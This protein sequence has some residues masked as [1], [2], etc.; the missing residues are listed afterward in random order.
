MIWRELKEA[1]ELEEQRLGVSL[2][3]LD[4]VIVDDYVE[5]PQRVVTNLH[6]TIHRNDA[7]GSRCYYPNIRLSV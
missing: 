2:D 3:D 1:V 6:A 5:G 7:T 4:V